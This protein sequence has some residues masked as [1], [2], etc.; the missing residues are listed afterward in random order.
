METFLLGVLLGLGAAVPVGP[1]N[2]EMLNRHIHSNALAGGFFGL[3]ACTVDVFYLGLLWLGLLSIL[4]YPFFLA[5]LG[6]IGAFVLFYFAYHALKNEL[7]RKEQLVKRPTRGYFRHWF[8]GALMTLTNPYTIVFWSSVG[9]QVGVIK[10]AD[11][12]L[13]AIGLGLLAGTVTWVVVFNGVLSI[14]RHRFTLA[15]QRM[16][17]NLG[18]GLLFMLGVLGLYRSLEVIL[19]LL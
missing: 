7:V 11:N 19:F 14:Y 12:Q 5:I 13:L 10:Q 3:G 4:N 15:I 8:D 17:N 2:I 18:G 1:V 9:S 6:T 16:L